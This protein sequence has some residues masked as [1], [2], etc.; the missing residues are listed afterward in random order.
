M[1]SIVSYFFFLLFLLN[2]LLLYAVNQSEK[3]AHN[4]YIITYREPVRN[5]SYR[6]HSARA[7]IPSQS[8][9]DR[10]KQ[11]IKMLCD[12][13]NKDS[14]VFS[15]EKVTRM[16]IE[17][18]V[19][20]SSPV[21]PSR[22]RYRRFSRVSQAP[23]YDAVDIFKANIDESLAN[24]LNKEDPHI[25]VEPNFLH[26]K[27]FS[28]FVSPDE[29]SDEESEEVE[30]QEDNFVEDV[31]S[32]L[33]Q[34]AEATT[35]NLPNVPDETQEATET[36]ENDNNN[37]PEQ[38]VESSIPPVIIT[39][40]NPP[41][42]S[43]DVTTPLPSSPPLPSEIDP[44][45]SNDERFHEQWAASVIQK[46]HSWAL[47]N[48]DAEPII[49]AV[50]D[51]GAD[52]NHPDIV[53]NLY[54]N[55]NE[56]PGNGIDDD[57]NNYIDDVSGW[58]FADNDNDP[59]TTDT[60]GAHV[61]G[62]IAA[63]TNNG[64]GISGF[65]YHNNIKLLIL[66]VFHEGE[67]TAE[68]SAIIQAINY[69]VRIGA[70][71]INASLGSY[72]SFFTYEQAVLRATASGVVVVSAAG[73]DNSSEVS[74][75]AGYPDVLSVA[76]SDRSGERVSFSNYGSS[77]DL[78][79]PG[80]GILAPIYDD[81]YDYYSGTS[82][83][84]PMVAGTASLILLKNPNYTPR[85]VIRTIL[86]NVDDRYV[87]NVSYI[88]LGRL[89]TLNAL[90]STQEGNIDAAETSLTNRLPALT[91]LVRKNYLSSYYTVHAESSDN[92]SIIR[93]EIDADSYSVTIRQ[94]ATDQI[95][96]SE[97]YDGYREGVIDLINVRDIFDS[98]GLSG[99]YILTFKAF[100][101]QRYV[102]AN[103][104]IWYGVPSLAAQSDSTYE[105]RI[106]AY[107]SRFEDE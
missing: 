28:Y 42:S 9:Y 35:V 92:V 104:V 85:Q 67:D 21:R 7:S 40:S 37:N 100:R 2:P 81:S 1:C 51:D 11:K 49:V 76:A 107:H 73:N 17:K 13:E 18:K 44:L 27:S 3:P 98:R 38:E 65:S 25:L 8:N 96:F 19:K 82:M 86:D 63:E 33:R 59:H 56:I 48:S 106:V 47:E 4:G 87:D 58:D 31:A 62:I 39:P 16:N 24:R 41:Q 83:A 22:G 88:G 105:E 29:E 70:R 95:V 94:A 99:N 84:S 75:P 12:E 66:K 55:P 50:I 68:S 43:T 93:G 103:L 52:M 64:I 46:K 32:A 14:S 74:Y 97:R 91:L 53:N 102:V 36:E 57:G 10:V 6:R 69:A 71:V 89:N 72:G 5:S 23:R 26:T 30:V 61:A 60:H 90:L 15:V 34:V 79:A 101:G 78:H 54:I 77:V 80:E 20:A 45:T